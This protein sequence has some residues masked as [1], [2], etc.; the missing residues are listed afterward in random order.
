MVWS[1]WSEMFRLATSVS[2]QLCV[3]QWTCAAS[4]HT[5]LVKACPLGPLEARLKQ[6]VQ[7]CIAARHSP[8][9]KQ[10][11]ML[12]HSH[13]LLSWLLYKTLKILRV[14]KTNPD[15]F[16]PFSLWWKQ[17]GGLLTYLKCLRLVWYMSLKI[18][19]SLALRFSLS[20]AAPG[21][22]VL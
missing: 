1:H 3:I 20:L 13:W 11:S 15:T 21:I 19:H 9:C 22:L 10:I 16:E 2:T 14:P 17:W 7:E 12:K 4:F 5:T 6:G 8:E 18:A